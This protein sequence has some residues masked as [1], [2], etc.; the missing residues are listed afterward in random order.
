MEKFTAKCKDEQWK[1]Y[2][3]YNNAMK[4]FQYVD[5]WRGTETINLE[6]AER[7]ATELNKGSRLGIGEILGG[8][9]TT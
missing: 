2:G 1:T 8:L 7:V 5:E 3:V 9:H 6:E 4:E